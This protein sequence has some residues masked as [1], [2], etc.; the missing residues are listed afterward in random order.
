MVNTYSKP[1]YSHSN[2]SGTK[3]QNIYVM[4]KKPDFTVI[5]VERSSLGT[6]IYLKFKNSGFEAANFSKETYLRNNN[7][8]KEYK[9]FNSVGLPLSPS[10]LNLS[11][12][13]KK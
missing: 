13:M 7:T 11:L 6:T 9:I 4:S 5:R 3:T 10:G 8:G 12:K 2:D 1:A